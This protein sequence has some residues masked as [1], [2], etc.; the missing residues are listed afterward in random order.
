MIPVETLN[1]AEL[2]KVRIAC[3]YIF[4]LQLARSN[5]FL[6]G[7]H[8]DLLKKAYR[9]K[10]KK[11]HP[12]FHHYEQAEMINKRSERFIKIRE[13]YE[14]L[15]SYFYKKVQTI[16]KKSDRKGKIIAIGG[17]KG[18][19]GKSLFAV[20]LSVLLSNMGLRTVVI[21][22]DLGGANLHL[23]LGEI[24]IN[25]NIN[26]FL[27][28][29]ISS[30]QQAMV[31]TKYGPSL[32]GGNSSQ[33]GA[34]NISFMRKQK[35]LKGIKNIDAD[36]IIIDLGG[37]TTYNILDFFLLADH[38]VV[39]TTCDPASYLDAYNFIKAALYRKLSRLFGPETNYNAQKDHDL[40][41]LICE[42]TTSEN[43][44]KIVKIENLVEK[45]AKQLPGSLPVLSEAISSFSPNLVVNRV[46][47]N[48]N[49]SQIVR[50][51]QEVSSK[52][53]SIKVKYL[54]NIPYQQEIELSTRSLVPI[55]T[56]STNSDLARKM[57]HIVENFLGN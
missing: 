17:A 46:P 37:D 23:Y 27:N 55:V 12:D 56:S 11:Y 26:D 2:Q 3:A 45:V 40:E 22:L 32:I 6:K 53:L 14:F 20:N 8:F 29:N 31:N 19:I 18:G 35:L 49:I 24:F 51:I 52:M 36:Y 16:S 10:V 21:D 25:S 34:A 5:K 7:L 28:K 54:G 44:S 57:S 50:R 30:L 42:A 47:K 43:G 41:R 4:S 13:S 48:F 33:L 15:N 38:G 1:A 39:M 9:K